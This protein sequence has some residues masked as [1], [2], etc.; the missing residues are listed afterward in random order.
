M[1][2]ITTSDNVIFCVAKDQK[3][4]VTHK[5][6][7]A[8]NLSLGDVL[9][10]MDK[11]F[12]KIMRIRHIVDKPTTI[13]Y[14]T[15]KDHHCYFIGENGV[16]VHNGPAV[17]YAGSMIFKGLAYFTVGSA[18]S[19]TVA[20]CAVTAGPA[21]VAVG[22]TVSAAA[23]ITGTVEGIALA[24]VAATGQTGAI[25]AGATTG[26]VA[27]ASM[28]AGTTVAA[29]KVAAGI[30]VATGGVFAALMWLPTP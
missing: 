21:A 1:I 9:L 28:V 30:E 7:E 6:V 27:I 22:G 29:A 10:R 14:I 19:V 12:V 11:T 26:T 4:F 18:V 15:L 25:V 24:T 16:L 8:E 20:G 3:F 17:A 2:E 13:R 23:G 5:W